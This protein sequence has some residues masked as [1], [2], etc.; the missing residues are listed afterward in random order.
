[1]HEPLTTTGIEILARLENDEVKDK[2]R[3]IGYFTS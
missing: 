3:K 1:M 2:A